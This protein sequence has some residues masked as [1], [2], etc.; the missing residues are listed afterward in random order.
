V[1]TS[2][3]HQPRAM[4]E[5]KGAAPGITFQGYPVETEELDPRRWW[6]D[7]RTA[8]RMILEYSKYLVILGREAVL[9]L[10]PREQPKAAAP[11][12]QGAKG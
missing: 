6:R 2:D 10:G 7:P 11:A 5:L 1:V 12:K 8:R 3:Y 9:S 4:L